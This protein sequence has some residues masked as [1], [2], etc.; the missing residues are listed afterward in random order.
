MLGATELA[1]TG[2]TSGPAGRRSW[3]QPPTAREV[4]PLKPGATEERKMNRTKFLAGLCLTVFLA[5]APAFAQSDAK[6]QEPQQPAL[7]GAASILEQRKYV[8]G[9][10]IAI[11]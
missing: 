10:L 1:K 8:W 6:P 9:K 2:L 11:A 4:D 5:A 7:T 3:E